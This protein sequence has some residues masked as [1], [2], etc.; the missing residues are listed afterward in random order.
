MAAMQRG[1][2]E[3]AR[4]LADQAASMDPTLEAPLLL[5]AALSPPEE[6]LTYAQRALEI[7][8]GSD[9]AVKAVQWALDR[10]HKTWQQEQIKQP[11]A[12]PAPAPARP[13][14]IE[15]EAA[16]E[17]AAQQDLEDFADYK[18]ELIE[19]DQTET[20]QM[21]E[22]ALDVPPEP[23][24]PAGRS[25]LKRVRIFLLSLL[26]LIVL[27]VISGTLI[28]R[29]QILDL[30]GVLSPGN[31]C[32]AV[33]TLGPKA[34]EIRTLVPKP[35]GTFKAPTSHPERLYWLKGSDVN[36]VFVMLSSRENASLASAVQPG[37]TAELQWPNCTISTYRL[38]Q[39][40]TEQPFNLAEL[41]QRGAGITLFIPGATAASGY[42][43]VGE[44]IQ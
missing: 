29:T 15:I 3:T 12:E 39:V 17:S 26:A 30:L 31:D 20:R 44:L 35:D 25:P 4:Q 23:A 5:L 18:A 33:L 41:N 9:A 19:E 11:A 2:R 27:V 37:Q 24:A 13:E 14:P 1:D 7:N 10:V 43:L 6:G 28:Y 40:S 21:Q 16:P 34:F 8:P 38:S 32:Q 36:L 22:A 42:F